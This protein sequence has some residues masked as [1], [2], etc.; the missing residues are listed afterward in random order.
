MILL[1]SCS[2]KKVDEKMTNKVNISKNTINN[3]KD[4]TSILR[5]LRVK[6]ISGSCSSYDMALYDKLVKANSKEK[7]LTLKMN[8]SA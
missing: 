7:T 3:Y 4:N 5:D 6:V 8:A 1:F 2:E